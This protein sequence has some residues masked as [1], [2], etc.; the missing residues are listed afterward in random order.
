MK[1]ERAIVRNGPGVVG[2]DDG[3]NVGA[4]FCGFTACTACESE[5]H[6]DAW[7]RVIFIFDFGF[8]EGS[9]I[10]DAPI[11]RVCG[12]GRRSLFR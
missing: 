5:F 4:K 10:V 6:P 11:E 12:R 1:S 2:P 8:C 7:A 3:G 9:G